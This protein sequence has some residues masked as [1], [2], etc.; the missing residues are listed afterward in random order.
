[1]LPSSHA[2]KL[3]IESSTP[4]PRQHT[5][6]ISLPFTA[7]LGFRTGDTE[8]SCEYSK[9]AA[10]HRRQGVVLQLGELVVGLTTRTS[11]H[12][13][14]ERHKVQTPARRHTDFYSFYSTRHF[15][16]GSI[17]PPLPPNGPSAKF[18]S[19]HTPIPYYPKFYIKIIFSFTP[20]YCNL[21]H[22]GIPIKTMYVLI[23]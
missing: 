20:N 21:F 3:S 4:S 15:V 1:M 13:L 12:S 7:D 16:I 9:Q 14:Y 8:G 23:S 22:S 17:Q 19:V 10:V 18:N 11:P 2:N 6:T 5:P